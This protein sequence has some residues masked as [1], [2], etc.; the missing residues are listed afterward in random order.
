M[1][2]KSHK[3]TGNEE[4]DNIYKEAFNQATAKIRNSKRSYENKLAFNIKHNCKGLYA[5]IRS[6]QT[7]QDKLGSLEGSGGN[8]ITE[9]LL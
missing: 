5:Y 8:I 9:T 7:V 3:Q 6:T 1:M 4:N 2:W